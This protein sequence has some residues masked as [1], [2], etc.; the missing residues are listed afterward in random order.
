[1]SRDVLHMSN[2]TREKSGNEKE[3]RGK[4]TANTLQQ[5]INSI[6][7]AR[8]VHDYIIARER[9]VLSPCAPPPPFPDSA[10]SLS[11]DLA[12]TRRGGAPS[13]VVVPRGS[14][15]GVDRQEETEMRY[16]FH[17]KQRRKTRR[18]EGN[19]MASVRRTLG[20]TGTGTRATE[21]EADIE[22]DG[23]QART[24]E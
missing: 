13:L 11:C 15:K 10:A 12:Q 23:G 14:R 3:G 9:V 20:G 1:M 24:K 5:L 16:T 19:V 7:L 17:T 2:L 4:K 6:L 22:R 8:H 21:I 18:T